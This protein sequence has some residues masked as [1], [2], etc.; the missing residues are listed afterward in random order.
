[1]KQFFVFATTILGFLIFNLQASGGIALKINSAEVDLSSADATFLLHG[2]NFDL[3]PLDIMIGGNVIPQSAC[4]IGPI[5][6][7]CSLVGT[8]VVEGSTYTVSISGGNAPGK[9][10]EIDIFIPA[11]LTLAQCISGDFVECFSGEPATKTVGECQSGFRTCSADGTWNNVC[12]GE[13]L[14]QIE[15]CNDSLDNDCD[16]FTDCADIDCSENIACF[17]PCD[18][19]PCGVN[20]ICT[21]S[22]GEAICQCVDGYY[23]LNGIPADGCECFSTGVEICDGADNDCNGEVDEGLTGMGEL[24]SASDCQDILASCND[25]PSGI[26]WVD[27]GSGPEVV[28]CDFTDLP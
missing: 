21:N 10:E 23:D 25:C 26:Y 24:C 16:T 12:E 22:G 17:D 28:Y 20:T 11:G 18:P 4:T 5:S 3:A 2:I 6:I 7:E 9:N 14:P 19:N 15:T 8:P 13:V 1:M 27:S